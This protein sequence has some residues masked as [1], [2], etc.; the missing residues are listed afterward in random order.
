[1]RGVRQISLR[2]V[3]ANLMLELG[4]EDER[5]ITVV[6]DISHGILRPFSDEFPGR[7]YNVGICEPTIVGLAAGLAH[8]GF[9]PFVHTIAPFLVERPYEQIKLDF[10]Y[11][12][13]SGNFVS[14][15]GSFDYS[16][17]GC[18]HH[19]YSDVSMFAQIEGSSVYLPSSPRELEI[20]MTQGYKSPGT[21]YFRLT[22]NPHGVDFSESQI[23][24]GQAIVAK[25]G[26]DVT[27]L[28]LGP[29]LA[30]ALEVARALDPGI[31][32][33]VLYYH[34]FKPFDLDSLRKSVAKTS[35]FVSVEELATTGGLF[36]SALGALVGVRLDAA[37]Q[38]AVEGFVRGYGSYGELCASAG[39]DASSIAGAVQECFRLKR[40]QG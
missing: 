14:V 26:R 25:P 33:E 2:Q 10:G 40:R 37:I 7:Y 18:S 24:P 29:Q 6:G 15:G 38:V 20:L 34:S 30:V 36:H 5:V 13:L 21:N 39:L 17:L 32:V 35:A 23:I 3:W 12:Q 22:E 27:I 8:L 31:S 4:R 28:A 1:M 11:Q 16:Q 9:V 19:T